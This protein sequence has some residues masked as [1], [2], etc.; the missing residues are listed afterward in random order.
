MPALPYYIYGAKTILQV[1]SM[2][3]IDSYRKCKRAHRSAFLNF[4]CLLFPEMLCD[5]GEHT[6]YCAQLE[7]KDYGNYGA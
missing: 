1:D 4:A 6:L 3:E 2:D 7:Y 5:D